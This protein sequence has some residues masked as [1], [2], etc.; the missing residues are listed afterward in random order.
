[1]VMTQGVVYFEGDEVVAMT[2][3]G[4]DETRSVEDD[5]RSRAACF[6]VGTAEIK[7]IPTIP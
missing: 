1:M 4:N 6:G 5:I 3:G 7:M 2:V